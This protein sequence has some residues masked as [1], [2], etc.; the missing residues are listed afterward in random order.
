VKVFTSVGR[1]VVT[2]RTINRDLTTDSVSAYLDEIG[3]TPLLT[4]EDERELGRAIEAGREA[5]E[6]LNAAATAAERQRLQGVIRQGDQAKERFIHAN[7]RLVVSIA[8]RYRVG[9]TGVDLLDLFQEGNIG[10]IRAVEK[11]DWRKGFKS[12]T[13]G[14]WWIRQAVQR[15]L[16]EK[17]RPL[18]VSSR[19]HDAAI[20]VNRMDADLHAEMGRRPSVEELA[21]RSGLALDLVKEVRAVASVTSLQQPIGEDGAV[22]GDFIELDDEHG[23]EDIAVR[24]DALAELERAIARLGEREQL[25][26][27]RRYGFHDEVPRTLGEI[28]KILNLTPERVH[29]IEKAALCRLRHPS[30]GLR[31]HDLM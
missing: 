12:S 9:L 14:T 23:P 1:F 19:V 21:E 6:Q 16:L 2:Q 27:R 13:Y 25:I 26:L 31:E 5:R 4:A 15:A 28:G 22:V 10:L 8:N 7:L 30:F 17:G 29:Q 11:F 20:T 18:R 24:V 3:R